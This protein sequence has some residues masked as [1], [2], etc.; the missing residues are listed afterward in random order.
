[1][2][3]KEELHHIIDELSD[4]TADRL[5]ILVRAFV[6]GKAQDDRAVR[7]KEP[8]D[9]MKRGEPLTPDD[10]LLDLVGLITNDGP[11]DVAANHDT[12]LAA[13]YGNWRQP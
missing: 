4:G 3:V 5:L 9:W 1:M 6:A 11:D 8:V 13:I 7:D 12:Y 10:P 2:T